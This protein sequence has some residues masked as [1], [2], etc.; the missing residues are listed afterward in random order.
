[1]G[2]RIWRRPAEESFF[3]KVQYSLI[4]AMDPEREESKKLTPRALA[5]F[6]IGLLIILILNL[7]GYMK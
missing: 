4:P 3:R 7:L 5:L 2:L 1:M 6:G